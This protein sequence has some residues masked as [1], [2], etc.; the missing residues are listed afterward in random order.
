MLEKNSAV[1]AINIFGAWKKL[2]VIFQ[3]YLFVA[4]QKG[5]QFFLKNHQL[6]TFI[7]TNYLL[8]LLYNLRIS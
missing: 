2:N 5:Y 1:K 6:A 7:D 8:F 4:K 3:L